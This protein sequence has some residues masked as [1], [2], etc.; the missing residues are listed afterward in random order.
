MYSPS[1]V[2]WGKLRELLQKR[3]DARQVRRVKALD[4]P[5]GDRLRDTVYAAR[6]AQRTAV[7]V[8]KVKKIVT[9]KDAVI[10]IEQIA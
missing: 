10:L 2:G 9:V 8:E 7:S 1:G 3:L 4:E 5:T 6:G